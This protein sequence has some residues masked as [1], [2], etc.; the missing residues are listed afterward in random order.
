MEPELSAR[1]ENVNP[2]TIEFG[3]SSVRAIEEVFQ[4]C[5]MTQWMKAVATNTDNLS[6]VLG[7]K[8]RIHSHRLSPDLYT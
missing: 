7:M 5:E 8:N 1:P 4:E 3:V 2:G 6:L